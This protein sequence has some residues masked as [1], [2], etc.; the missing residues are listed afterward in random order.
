MLDFKCS[1]LDSI[2]NVVVDSLY[3]VDLQWI[4]PIKSSLTF[5]YVKNTIKKNP[6]H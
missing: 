4:F 6:E 3:R 5:I 2:L 1:L